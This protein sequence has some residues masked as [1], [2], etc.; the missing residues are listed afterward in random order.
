MVIAQVWGLAYVTFN[1]I[2]YYTAPEDT[3]LIYP[4]FDWEHET[5]KA[6]VYSLASL[7]ILTP[8]LAVLHAGI[9][10]CVDTAHGCMA[11]T[12]FVE[13]KPT[14]RTA[15]RHKMSGFALTCRALLEANM[16]C[17]RIYML[18]TRFQQ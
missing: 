3:R 10:R 17:V 5:L 16:R 4:I 15:A 11:P 13:R 6:A 1:V 18:P 12:A 14:S 2:W 7:L 9:C 8:L